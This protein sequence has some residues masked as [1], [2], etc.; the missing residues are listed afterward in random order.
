[1][2]RCALVFSWARR[3]NCENRRFLRRAFEGHAHA[4]VRSCVF[5]GVEGEL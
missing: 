1:M 5:E 2:P 4:K 3:V